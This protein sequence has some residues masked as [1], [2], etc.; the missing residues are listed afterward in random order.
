MS[1]WVE[2]N[3]GGKLFC[4]TRN[5]L[6]TDSESMLA[7]LFD[8]DTEFRTETDSKGRI[9]IDRVR[10]RFKMIQLIQSKTKQNRIQYI[11]VTF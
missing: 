11:F 9:L 5:T 6:L 4:T 10:T 3:V 1:S 2:L 7:K 8:P